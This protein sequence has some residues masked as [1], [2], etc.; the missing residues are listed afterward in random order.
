MKKCCTDSK[1][2]H[3]FQYVIGDEIPKSESPVHTDVRGSRQLTPPKKAPARMSKE[4]RMSKCLSKSPYLT[5]CWN[6]CK[7]TCG[8]CGQIFSTSAT[9]HK[10]VRSVLTKS[11]NMF[12]SIYFLVLSNCCGFFSHIDMLN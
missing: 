10:H 4:T 2:F 9:L 1:R 6:Q 11:H 8:M 7:E 12:C 5:F 3:F